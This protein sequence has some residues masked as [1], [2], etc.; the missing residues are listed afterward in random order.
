MTAA[1]A[2]A[3]KSTATAL[4]AAPAVAVGVIEVVVWL[5]M[6]KVFAF[7]TLV[8]VLVYMCV[9]TVSRDRKLHGW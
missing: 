7:C 1:A 6:K 2:T 3:A 4:T 8:V 5:L 9:A